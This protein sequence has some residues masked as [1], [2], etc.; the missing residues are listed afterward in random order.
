MSEVAKG[1][2]E[3]TY[4]LLKTYYIGPKLNDIEH[5]RDTCGY[6]II[7]TEPPVDASTGEEVT[8]GRMCGV[9]DRG[10]TAHGEYDTIEAARAA[11][12][13]LGYSAP[14]SNGDNDDEIDYIDMFGMTDDLEPVAVEVYT[15]T[16][17]AK[18]AWDIDDY[19]YDYRK[20]TI[21]ATTTD[22]EIKK[23]SGEC[24][25]DANRENIYI[26]GDVSEFLTAYRDELRG[27]NE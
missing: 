12:I 13:R 15:T 16:T 26:N 25:A 20:S 11:A 4:Y 14:V 10:Y 7:Q 21:T 8:D 23:L 1:L 18:T 6:M 3:M 17:G 19:L 24:E 22:E 27:R 9:N 5:H 2:I